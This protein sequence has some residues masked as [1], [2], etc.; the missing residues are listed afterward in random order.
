MRRRWHESKEFKETTTP[1]PTPSQ[2]W[3]SFLR[4]KFAIVE[5]YSVGQCLY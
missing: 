4:M 3:I 5:I 1:P 2:E